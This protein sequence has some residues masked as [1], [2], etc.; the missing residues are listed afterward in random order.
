MAVLNAQ[1]PTLLDLAQIKD[2]DGRISDVVEILNETNQVLLDMSW[3][4]GNLPTGNKTT[5]R[6][7]IPAPTWRGT[8]Q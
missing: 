6:T 1:N 5:I 2:P 3:V 4:E 7:G 8:A